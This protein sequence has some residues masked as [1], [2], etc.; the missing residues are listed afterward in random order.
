MLVTSANKEAQKVILDR[1]PYVHYLV[2]FQ[3]DELTIWVLIN[4]GSEI[5][6]ITPAYAINLGF[7]VW[8]TNVGAQKIDNSLLATYRMVIAAFQVLDKLERAHFFQKSF[9]LADT[10]ME[11]IL[12]MPFITF[13]M[14]T[15]SLQRKSIPGGPIPPKRLCLPPKG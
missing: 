7:K 9:L 10:S 12:G 2:Q 3:K 4:S 15:V 6:T 1:V 14:Q 8:R 5:N 13:A 11:V